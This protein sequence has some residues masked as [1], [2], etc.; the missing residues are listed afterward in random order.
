MKKVLIVEDHEDVRVSLS[1]ILK[2]EG[3]IVEAA[4][5]GLESL[6]IISKYN[7]IPDFLIVDYN[8]PEING[9]EIVKNVKKIKPDIIS[10]LLTAD[11]SLTANEEVKKNIDY[12][13]TKPYDPVKIIQI[14]KKGDNNV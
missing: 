12:F 6:E 9:V 7:F 13:I 11:I 3:F 1:L 5:K 14:L 10:L 2:R 8:L 4:E